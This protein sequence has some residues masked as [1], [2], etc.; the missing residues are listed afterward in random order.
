MSIRSVSKCS[1]TTLLITVA[2]SGTLAVPAVAQE[3]ERPSRRELNGHVFMPSAV[4]RD[5]FVSTFFRTTTGAG[6]AIGLEIPV[7]NLS[8]S[9]IRTVTGDIA[10]AQ[11]GFEYQQV[12]GTWLALRA[13]I[14][15]TAR[16]STSVEALF[17]EGITAV[18]GGSL[19][20]TA[21]L[22][23]RDRWILS[24]TVDYST[25]SL[26][27]VTPLEFAQNLA[28][29][30]REIIESGGTLP[31][32]FPTSELLTEASAP[33]LRGGLRA[34]YAPKPWLGFTGLV[35]TGWTDPFESEERDRGLFNGGATVGVD[36]GAMGK[37]PL[38]VLGSVSGQSKGARGSDLASA[39]TVFGL[40]LFYTGRRE[41]SVGVEMTWGQIEQTEVNKS[42]DAV[43]ARLLVRYDF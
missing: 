9:L 39:A 25:N 23:Q 21:R 11:L 7:Y 35:E 19:G 17:A 33:E 6:A 27:K 29:F 20:A 5:P 1:R 24:A 10:F 16:L 14:G 13:S 15:G 30:V 31:D 43:L 26:T 32:T 28:D 4:V 12:L 40:G 8:D 34:A 22:V 42:I 18:G 36:F 37:I 41:F 2:F 38:G 3:A